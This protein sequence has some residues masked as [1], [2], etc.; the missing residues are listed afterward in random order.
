MRTRPLRRVAS[1]LA[2]LVAALL[3]SGCYDSTAPGATLRTLAGTW[4]L[5][6]A[7]AVSLNGV[8]TL[9]VQANQFAIDIDGDGE[10]SVS[11]EIGV[12]ETG[13]VTMVADSLRF[14]PTSRAPFTMS[15]GFAGARLR[16]G[17][18]IMV[19][20]DLTDESTAAAPADFYFSL[21]RP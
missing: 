13:T 10:Y 16:L 12:I 8:D 2:V 5:E 19:D 18:R 9:Q 17:R 3:S 7:F 6:S 11:E 21:V 4:T 1:L 15:W 20:L 14:E